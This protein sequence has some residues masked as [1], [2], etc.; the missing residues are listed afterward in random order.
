M[1]N[2]STYQADWRIAVGRLTRQIYTLLYSTNRM[3][4]GTN[5]KS[6]Q[7]NASANR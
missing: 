7:R 1:I 3:E 5:N 6:L 4:K 2:E